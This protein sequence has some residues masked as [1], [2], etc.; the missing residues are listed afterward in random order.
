VSCPARTV[1]GTVV[2][3]PAAGT[4]VVVEVEAVA[5]VVGADDPVVVVGAG[6]AWCRA[7]EQLVATIATATRITPVVVLLFVTKRIGRRCGLGAG[8]TGRRR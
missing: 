1:N 5:E 2:V 3:A 6:T 4:L 8:G 7:L